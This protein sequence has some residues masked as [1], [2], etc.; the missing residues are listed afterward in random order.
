VCITLIG[1]IFITHPQ[2]DPYNSRLHVAIG[3]SLPV[4]AHLLVHDKRSGKPSWRTVMAGFCFGVAVLCLSA[5]AEVKEHRGH[6]GVSLQCQ[7][8]GNL[9]AT[10]GGS[11][12]VALLFSGGSCCVLSSWRRQSLRC[13]CHGERSGCTPRRRRHRRRHRMLTVPVGSSARHG[14]VGVGGA[15]YEMVPSRDLAE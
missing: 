11:F 8:A 3:G 15:S 10:L 6:L 13:A 2:G 4:G 12:S 7:P 14:G 9:L 5:F 1:A